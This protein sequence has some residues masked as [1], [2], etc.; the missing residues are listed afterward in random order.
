MARLSEENA[1]KLFN[2]LAQWEVIL[3]SQ[4][5]EIEV[6]AEPPETPAS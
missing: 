2:T 5:G 3:T 4:N 6:P 1:K